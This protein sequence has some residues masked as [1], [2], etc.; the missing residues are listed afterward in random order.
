MVRL[1]KQN[2]ALVSML[3]KFLKD[4]LPD[5]WR[6][7]NRNP[8]EAAFALEGL[9]IDSSEESRQLYADRGP[10]QTPEEILEDLQK[11]L[12]GGEGG[13]GELIETIA[14]ILKSGNRNVL[15]GKTL[16]RLREAVL[17]P[18]ER[19]ALKQLLERAEPSCAICGKMFQ[20]GEVASIFPD[21]QGI[22]VCTRCSHPRSKACSHEGCNHEIALPAA[23]ERALAKEQVCDHHSGAD[24]EVTPATDSSVAHMPPSENSIL[25]SMRMFQQAQV[26]G[27]RPS[28]PTRVTASGRLFDAANRLR[29]NDQNR[30]AGSARGLG[31]PTPEVARTIRWTPNE[32]LDILGRDDE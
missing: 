13:S 10:L 31:S 9:G 25:E 17:L 12:V 6:D 4:A 30:M 14:T 21:R 28:A 3:L 1:D 22:F 8:N 5:R 24:P 23:V 32:P 29:Q 19:G 26:I 7:F 15:G 20:L 16:E 11:Q 27:D 2:A 18:S